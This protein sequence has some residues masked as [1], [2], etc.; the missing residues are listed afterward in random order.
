MK[1]KE[2]QDILISENKL[3]LGEVIKII[4][5]LKNDVFE[6]MGDINPDSHD[7]S[8]YLGEMN[9]FYICMDLLGMVIQNDT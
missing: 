4:Y 8:W 3:T 7:Y 6:K 9:G 1:P 2:L 5:E